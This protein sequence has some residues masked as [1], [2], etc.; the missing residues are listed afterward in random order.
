M[1]VAALPS[2]KGRVFSTTKPGLPPVSNSTYTIRPQKYKNWSDENLEKA[3][4]AVKY[5]MTLRRA[6]AEYRIPKS[7]LHDHIS[8]KILPGS[9]SGRRHLDDNEEN[10][11]VRFLLGCAELG[12]PRTRKMF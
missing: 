8:G 5:G 11:L 6:A 10:E 9:K 2:I 4:D 7:T 1:A 12:Y 3:V